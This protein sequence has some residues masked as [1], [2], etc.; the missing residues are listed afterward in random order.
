MTISKFGSLLL[1]LLTAS[2]S[3]QCK[4]AGMRDCE[5]GS[6]FVSAT[7]QGVLAGG[8]LAQL[9]SEG[10]T[11]GSVRKENT[12]ILQGTDSSRTIS[13]FTTDY[14]GVGTYEI[15]G[16]HSNWKADLSIQNLGYWSTETA[17][18]ASGEINIIK[19]CETYLEGS[20]RFVAETASG[21]QADIMNGTFLVNF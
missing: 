9:T 20:F 10:P 4:D 12:I 6:T 19:D 2:L 17:P 1:F 14:Q 21:S 8:E 18:A 5:G 7:I 11:F 15:G 3:W 13:L 16:Q